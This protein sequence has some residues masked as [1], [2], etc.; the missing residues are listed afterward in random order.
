MAKDRKFKNTV[1]IK[2][3]KDIS[4]ILCIVLAA[5]AIAAGGYFIW[6]NNQNKRLNQLEANT[7]GID[8]QV[9]EQRAQIKKYFADYLSSDTARKDIV[10]ATNI[11]DR[12]FDS[13]EAA[14]I[15][16][17]LTDEQI[18]KL[19]D[20][21]MAQMDYESALQSASSAEYRQLYNTLYSNV[22]KQ[23]IEN[24]KS[25]D[26]LTIKQQVTY[27]VDA[28]V[29]QVESRYNSI[30]AKD[31]NKS[32]IE[33]T[34][35]AYVETIVE[36]TINNMRVDESTKNNLIK[37]VSNEVASYLKQHPELTKDGKDGKTGIDGKDGLDAKDGY[38]PVYGSDY[39]TPDE[40]Q[41]FVKLVIPDSIEYISQALEN[42]ENIRVTGIPG[43]SV[44][45]DSLVFKISKCKKDKT[46]QNY[47][48]SVTYSRIVDGKVQESPDNPDTITIP[49][50]SVQEISYVQNPSGD[51]EIAVTYD[52][53]YTESISIESIAA[54]Y[55]QIYTDKLQD[56]T[57]S[58]FNIPK[59][60]S[61]NW[62]AYDDNPDDDVAGAPHK[63]GEYY[64]SIHNI[65]LQSELV[66]NDDGT[67]TVVWGCTGDHGQTTGTRKNLTEAETTVINFTKLK[68]DAG[69]L[70]TDIYNAYGGYDKTE[71]DQW[72]EN[73]LTGQYNPLTQKDVE[74]KS[75]KVKAI[76]LAQ[77]ETLARYQLILDYM[78][79]EFVTNQVQIDAAAEQGQSVAP[80]YSS[81]FDLYEEYM[82]DYD[83]HGT[84]GISKIHKFNVT[85]STY[86]TD[87]NV[88][89]SFLTNEKLFTLKNNGSTCSYIRQ[90]TAGGL[91]F[92][93]DTIQEQLR[94]AQ[95]SHI[96]DYLMALN[97]CLANND[98]AI[99]SQLSYVLDVFN[100]YEAVS[101][102]IINGITSTANIDLNNIVEKDN[103]Y[104]YKLSVNK[105]DGINSDYS[106]SN[107]DV[108]IEN[109]SEFRKLQ[110]LYEF[111]RKVMGPYAS[112]TY[113]SDK[114]TVDVKLIP[115][116][117][118]DAW[119]DY[120]E[121]DGAVK[122][123]CLDM[124]TDSATVTIYLDK[125]V[126]DGLILNGTTN[127]Q[128]P[129]NIGL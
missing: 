40:I 84:Y 106:D 4:G 44:D 96:I 60:G 49:L 93:G 113:M 50:K 114:I 11:S 128:I 13:L 43:Y 127:I 7:K 35:Q 18:D 6:D 20:L 121:L 107:Q 34:Q 25:S 63:Y 33:A 86:Y 23:V 8:E 38:T 26:M 59:V 109:R 72:N 17:V 30:K 78:N 67:S 48:L 24:I 74:S 98:G 19:V 52:N 112:D 102:V 66:V 36:N 105:T 69:K 81:L 14:G 2:E 97:D 45:E 101:S 51:D 83:G 42:G 21:A 89:K 76:E 117:I 31:S 95:E 12:L 22:R 64:C 126:I 58:N 53:G 110:M 82:S 80:V 29:N 125:T 71:E 90:D 116:E 27:D 129:V 79:E 118:P 87:G 122:G 111:G 5:S 85:G 28:I 124:K 37:S 103:F 54:K 47:S 123:G 46:A 91:T 77:A 75:Y 1:K 92:N 9:S 15:N 32:N 10:T 88:L 62:I 94:A 68:T 104:V 3:M 57:V 108:N 120:T 61:N 65:K 39:Y 16:T 41:E 99:H 73:T 70:I 56:L 115:T 119:L 100:H 55:A